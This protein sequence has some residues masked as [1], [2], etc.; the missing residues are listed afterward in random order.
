MVSFLRGG[1]CGSLT[2][3]GAA[4]AAT[5]AVTIGPLLLTMVAT[6]ALTA[7]SVTIARVGIAAGVVVCG[8][9]VVVCMGVDVGACIMVGVGLAGD[10]CT[11]LLLFKLALALDGGA[12]TMTEL[13]FAIVVV[14]ALAGTLV[15]VVAIGVVVIAAA[16]LAAA[17]TIVGG[18]GGAE[19]GAAVVGGGPPPPPRDVGAGVDVGGRCM[20]GPCGVVN[21]GGGG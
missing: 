14:I 11:I 9:V 10:F 19:I 15:F 13:G 18:T 20:G 12:A 2:T 21:G 17:D 5:V 4:V 8:V 1:A 16:A 7:A 6:G 3:P